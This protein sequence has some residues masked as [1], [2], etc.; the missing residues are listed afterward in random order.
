MTKI[1][2]TMKRQKLLLM[3]TVLALT[4]GTSAGETFRGAESWACLKAHPAVVNSV[5]PAADGSVLSLRGEWD[6]LPLPFL[7]RRNTPGTLQPK[8]EGHYWTLTNEI[9]R[10][11]V[12]GCWEAQGVGSN[13]LSHTWVCKWDA[14]PKPLRHTFWGEGWYRKTVRIPSDWQG[15]RI[16]LKSGLIGSVGWIWVNG[17]Q[18]AHVDLF[19]GTAKYEITDFVRP[20]EEALVIVQAINTGTSRFGG[21]ASLNQ[22]GGILRDIELE[23]TPA[24][25]WIDD[26]WVRGDFDGRK[27]EV[28]AEVQGRGGE[29]WK[30][31]VL[32]ATVEGETIESPIK[33][34]NN[35]NNQTIAEVP[36]SNSNS[37]LQLDLPLR[38]FR[39]WSPEHPNLYTAK[40]ELVSADGRVRQTRFERFGVRKFEVRGKDF[41][42]ND[43]PFFVRGA[44]W[45][46]IYPL[47]GAAPADRDLY[48]RL[49]ARIRAA[50][51]NFC[52]FHTSC[53]P[54]ELFEAADELGLMLE[55]E[56]PYY[57]DVPATGQAFD[58]FRDAEELYLNY[59]R[60]PSFAVYSGGNEGWFGARTSAKLYA[61]VRGRDPDRLMLTQD[62]WLNPR[63]NQRGTADFQGGPMNVWPR[64]SVD[65]N[66]PFVCHEYLNLSVKFDSRLSDKFTGAWMP[67]TSRQARADWLARFG[68]GLADGDRLQD[69]QARLQKIWR[70]YGFESARLDPHCDG[71][72]YWSL[73]DACSPN[74][75]AYSG[76]ALFDPF[77]GDKPCGDT[78][79]SVAVY[80][81]P[82]CL[83]MDVSPQT[84]GP[85]AEEARQKEGPFT[86]FLTDFATNRVRC[87]GETIDA[88]FFLAHYG[89][90]PYRAAELVWQLTAEG[91]TLAEGRQSV[92][93]QALGGVREIAAAKVTVSEIAAACKAELRTV[94]RT[95]DGETLQNSWDWWLFPRRT[96]LDGRGVFVTEALRTKLAPRFE[97]LAVSVAEA[98][99]VLA[100]PDDPEAASARKDGRGLVTL[101][102]TEGPTN[103]RLGWWWMGRQMGAV[104]RPH[105]ALRH[106]PHDGLFSPLFF[107]IM[108]DGE[109]LT[110]QTRAD[111]LIVFGE[112]GSACYSYLAEKTTPAGAREFVVRGIDLLADTPEGDAIL[113]GII[114]ETRR[115]K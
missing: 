87:A 108:K 37:K 84:Y 20:G 58:P 89:D 95:A 112:G 43:N 17:E 93:D 115:S 14:S 40:V 46:V 51:F 70:K 8:G 11:Q 35:S 54:P 21:S 88:H 1:G 113:L 67:P 56:L 61:E 78:V 31:L 109:E 92:G 69:A 68:L 74:G 75:E 13:D 110:P 83:L 39:P 77:W 65:P 72:S 48:R 3:V 107:R 104:V 26:V 111:E 99:V 60:H 59:R 103:L 98:T 94:L 52:R 85:D 100:R 10:L 22:W 63:T 102:G 86:M 9:R 50:G 30:D 76:Q 90:R 44:G 45:H 41:Y 18:V 24:E 57:A 80:N 47:E 81:S 33:Q 2:D 101:A 6:F 15:R 91:R 36:L 82:S 7:S 105:P 19:C 73:Q 64:G 106:L 34:S 53:R 27:A 5:V 29:W 23:A 4:T 66:T 71:Y 12:P 16:W 55:P 38:H 32:R 25:V 79:E 114:Q 42:L 28:K 96:K 97:G 49:I 62:A